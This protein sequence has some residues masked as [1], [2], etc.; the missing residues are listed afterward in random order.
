[1]TMADTVAVMN[2]GAIAQQGDPRSV[3]LQPASAEVARITGAAVFLDATIR[4]AVAETALGS[5]P[6]GAASPG[7]NGFARVCV[8]PEQI[9]LGAP[10]S[11][12]AAKILARSFRGDHT[13]LTVAIGEFRLPVR[14]PT[15]FAA[16]ASDVEVALEG[17]CVAFPR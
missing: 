9:V 10:G 11:G 12:C 6:L 7:A 4:G 13:V 3:Y 2:Q 14:A 15:S 5:M 16:D 8:R 17:S 1:M